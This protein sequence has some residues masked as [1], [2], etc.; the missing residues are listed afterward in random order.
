[1]T[2]Q[3]QEEA[4]EASAAG[5]AAPGAQDIASTEA[6]ADDTATAVARRPSSLASLKA[7]IARAMQVAAD[8]ERERIDVSVGDDETAQV[9]KIVG[10]AAAEAAELSKHADEDVNL[11]NAWY[12][13]QVKRIR[14]EADRQ[15]DDRRSALEQSL[16][17]HGSLIEAEIESV[18]GAVQ[19]YRV[20]LGA[21]FG[22]LAEERDPSA[23][24]RL[25]GDLPDPPDLDDVRA[26][27]RSAAMQALEPGATEPS[28]P[29]DTSSPNGNGGSGSDRELVGVMD[30]ESVKE[31]AGSLN[32]TS[33]VASAPVPIVSVLADDEPWL[34]PASTDVVDAVPAST[35]MTPQ[36][37]VVAR[38]IRALK[39]RSTPTESSEEK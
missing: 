18:H 17:H 32:G 25:A 26:E 22:Q 15:I 29:T 20:S 36:E 11:V 34:A 13:D 8:R 35:E 21:F 4:V 31:H 9:E 37:N 6:R 24:A 39:S 3:L 30:Q 16:T 27:A 19:G 5:D 10:R 7:E 33:V 28:E 2:S 12:K 1:M 38:L 23:I 14:T